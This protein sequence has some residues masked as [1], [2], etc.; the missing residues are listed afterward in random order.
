MKTHLSSR[1]R[2]RLVL[3]VLASGLVL[4]L[5]LPALLRPSLE[6]QLASLPETERRAFYLRTLETLRTTCGE[7]P[8]EP[9][10][11][12]CREQAELVLRFP[13]CDAD[14]RALAD[15]FSPRSSR[16]SR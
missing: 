1:A 3:F 15:R 10:A 2:R 11:D 5:A 9:L 8:E 13:D 4:G 12:T 6:R 14:C 7:N 16:P